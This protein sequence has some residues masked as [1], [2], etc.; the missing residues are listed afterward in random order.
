MLARA[1]EII[2]LW[3]DVAGLAPKLHDPPADVRA[4]ELVRSCQTM[5]SAEGLSK[6]D[7]E[8]EI[9][10]DLFSFF[11]RQLIVSEIEGSAWHDPF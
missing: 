7:L 8:K 3:T 6:I 1:R 11:R 2:N 4:A 10:A 5:A 9:Q